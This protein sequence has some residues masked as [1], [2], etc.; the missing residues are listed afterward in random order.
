MSEPPTRRASI[1]SVNLKPMRAIVRAYSDGS[2]ILGVYGIYSD[3][4]AAQTAVES[5]GELGVSDHLQIVPFYQV[6]Q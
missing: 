2:A 1:N 6:N 5:L 3:D 4:E